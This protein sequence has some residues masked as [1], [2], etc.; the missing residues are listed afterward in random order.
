MKKFFNAMLLMAA[1]AFSVNVFVS[2]N[3]ELETNVQTVT[4][5]AT[6][7]ADAITK[8]DQELTTL[9]E[10]LKAAKAELT[11]AQAEL[12]AAKTAIN[13]AK[14]AAAAADAKAVA[15][16]AA[17]KTAAATAK[18]EAIAEAQKL[19]NALKSAYEA[20][21]A[22]INSELAGKA[23]KADIENAVKE[24]TASVTTALNTINAQIADIL[25]DLAKKVD[26]AD[27][28]A[29]VAELVSTATFDAKVAEL[30]QELANK[31]DK[32]DFDAKLAELVST[33]ALDAKVAELLKTLASKAEFEAK[34]AE[35]VS[36]AAAFDAKVAELLKADA[37]LDLRLKTVEAYTALIEALQTD[38][39][40]QD[41]K[42][43]TAEDEIDALRKNIEEINAKLGIDGSISAQLDELAKKVE[44]T[45]TAADLQTLTE[46]L[47]SNV[48][49]LQANIGKVASDLDAL[50]KRVA[51][52]E[53]ALAGI[54]EAL[55][56]INGNF[57][58]HQNAIVDL[59]NRIQSVVY[60]PETV[61]GT[62][63]KV[64]AY[65]FSNTF[66][67][68]V[69][70]EATYEVTPKEL[71]ANLVNNE[72]VKVYF[73]TVPVTKAE[74]AEVIAAKV[75]SAENGR[76]VVEG[77]I[78]KD[79]EKAFAAI[80]NTA[81]AAVAVAL[82]IEDV[83]T[84][85]EANAG[86]VVSAAYVPVV[87]ADNFAQD[88]T[89]NVVFY[90]GEAP[91]TEAKLYVSKPYDYEEPIALFEGYEV[92]IL[93]DGE[94]LT[95]QAANEKLGTDWGAAYHTTTTYYD[96]KGERIEPVQS[97]I[98]VTIPEGNG[99][100][101]TAR[102]VKANGEQVGYEA[103]TVISGLKVY[104]VE[105]DYELSS[106]VKVDYVKTPLTLIDAKTI[107]WSY[108]YGKT[109]EGDTETLA[110][111]AVTVAEG[112]DITTLTNLDGTETVADMSFEA[113]A[114]DAAG[115][116]YKAWVKFG[117][118][119]EKIEIIAGNVDFAK[120]EDLIYNFKAE[121]KDA[122]GNVYETTFAITAAAMPKDEVIT[123][124]VADQVPA[125]YNSKTVEVDP[126][127]QTL[128][129]YPEADHAAVAAVLVETAALEDNEIAL[130]LDADGAET[131]ALTI[132]RKEKYGE[133]TY[134][135]VV[136]VFEGIKYTYRAVVKLVPPTFEDLLLP[137]PVFVDE[138]GVVT[139]TGSINE[140]DAY[141]LNDIKLYDYI[142]RNN[143]D[144]NYREVTTKYELKNPDT[145][146]GVYV[147]TGGRV[148]WIPSN[149][150]NSAEFTVKMVSRIDN[151]VVLASLDIKTVTPDVLE[152]KAKD[153]CGSVQ[154]VPA[155]TN[156]VN[157]GSSLEVHDSVDD[158]VK[159]ITG[160]TFAEI[161]DQLK[162][163]FNIDLTVDTASAKAYLEKSNTE[164]RTG[165]DVLVSSNGD[166]TFRMTNNAELTDNIIV[167]VDVEMTH[168]YGAKKE[169]KQLEVKFIK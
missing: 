5:K 162:A 30:L 10:A 11:A 143:T 98:E 112:L 78:T 54:N 90:K 132:A 169:L 49:T 151:S 53:E 33:T 103:Y 157:L 117:V 153:V 133:K 91:V 135:K 96:N 83:K 121:L 63:T 76:I 100:G 150:L 152:L 70:F 120:G 127:A 145:T 7:N 92:R 19:V 51:A 25:K 166:V 39:D 160:D 142:I 57:T 97:I 106:D 111:A 108:M 80:Y 116:E 124:T 47:N 8:L 67:S 2:C 129:F 61:A 102:F 18:T 167:R 159:V 71:A 29:K 114:K 89:D 1:L 141:V 14:D 155:S 84:H 163:K 37:A 105:Y 20:E 123:L 74:A 107:A 94:Y 118:V 42:I 125:Y 139:L 95:L 38:D 137:N 9:D 13:E 46:S 52:L 134:E 88:L 36:T 131:S 28:D 119:E 43:K 79:N 168:N 56:G 62:I 148:T 34:V 3:D 147:T 69:T 138:N 126:I 82:N 55:V 4:D 158:E 41:V 75:V 156:I 31:V 165:T 85:F 140:S 44:A 40:A 87:P 93:I 16:D 60:V 161:E 68:A 22:R 27:F 113:V 109:W 65:T 50:T 104:G 72:N 128:K 26:K 136:E 77:T 86:T 144:P 149:G 154:Y 23:S 48:A 81:D 73:N 59:A 32:T 12:A 101:S 164:I 45:A 122:S 15:A 146:P 24:A 66:K 58:S 115:T 17:A 35:L 110:D 130:T 6:T 99:L 21:V 64:N